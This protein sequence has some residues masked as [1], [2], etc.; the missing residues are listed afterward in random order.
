ML[1]LFHRHYCKFGFSGN[2]KLFPF[3]KSTSGAREYARD[4]SRQIT[5]HFTSLDAM[6]FPIL[7]SN[8]C[9]DLKGIRSYFRFFH[10]L[11]VQAKT[12]S[13]N[14]NVFIK[15]DAL[16]FS[17]LHCLCAFSWRERE[18]GAMF[19]EQFSLAKMVLEGRVRKP[20]GTI[21]SWKAF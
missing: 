5:T 21:D 4:F 8:E 19:E 17:P 16:A 18:G 10:L 7:S 6:F 15:L 3:L 9:L 13:S 2:Q 11:P 12:F 20:Q 1:W 14:H